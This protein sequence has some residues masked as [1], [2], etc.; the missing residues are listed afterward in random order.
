MKVDILHENGCGIDQNLS[1]LQIPRIGEC[2]H[3]CGNE[4]GRVVDVVHYSYNDNA[5]IIVRIFTK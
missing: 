3:I 1:F 2:I 4:Y 5:E